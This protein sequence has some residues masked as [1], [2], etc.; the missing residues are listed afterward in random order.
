MKPLRN[1]ERGERT[2]KITKKNGRIYVL[3]IN[4]Q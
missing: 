2:H 1:S 4:K 3:P